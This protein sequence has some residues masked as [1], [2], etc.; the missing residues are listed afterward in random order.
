MS[1]APTTS[2]PPGPVRAPGSRSLLSLLCAVLTLGG[3]TWAIADKPM[4]GA[5]SPATNEPWVR[6]IPDDRSDE[7]LVF[8]AFSGGGTRAATFA[9]GALKELSETEV[10][11]GGE[12]RRLV[13][14]VDIISSVSGGSFSAAY[15][16]LFGDRIFRD[17]ETDFLRRDVEGELIARLF[18]PPNWFRLASGTYGR[19]DLAAAYYDKI[20]FEGAT[21]RDFLRPTAP[22]LVINATDLATGSRFGFTQLY[23][24]LLCAD[25]KTYPV[26]R[27][28]AASSAVPVLLSPI[29][30][31]NYTPQ[32]DY[33]PPAWLEQALHNPE[34]PRR[35]AEARDR[36]SYED[37]EKRRYVHLV[38][39]GIADNLGLRGA[40]QLVSL[41]DDTEETFRYI[42]HPHPRLILFILVDAETHREPTWASSAASPTLAELVDRVTSDQIDHF[43]FET[44]ELV[45]NAFEGWAAE[46]S[47]G[48]RPVQFEFVE[49]SFEAVRDADERAALNDIGTNF[50]LDDEDVDLLIRA[51]R[52]V[53]RSSDRFQA[54][55]ATIDG[56]SPE[57]EKM[58]S[59]KEGPK[60][61]PGGGERSWQE[62]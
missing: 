35:R 18:W 60:E 2:A 7:V 58:T 24:D 49:V 30:L 23:F 25:L 12:R 37:P 15:Y 6:Q 19:S 53:L 13:D 27:A 4:E 21:F 40:F 44:I 42:G 41:Q 1:P 20:L 10:V 39:G 54:A 36:L 46:L 34:D 28:V 8:L 55:L 50:S 62:D 61:G 9:Y 45:S 56:R 38:D 57:P 17:F 52:T 51:S 43:N 3:C 22:A 5:W 26:S 14:E 29:T 59:K 47:S 11:L 33:Q 16:G 48:D 31:R 32:C